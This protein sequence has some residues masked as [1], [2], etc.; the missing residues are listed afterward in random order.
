AVEHQHLSMPL[1]VMGDACRRPNDF[2][3]LD[4]YVSEEEMRRRRQ[5]IEESGDPC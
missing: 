5:N 3:V 4:H 2:L 1:S